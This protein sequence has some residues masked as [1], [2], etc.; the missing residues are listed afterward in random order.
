MFGLQIM[1]YFGS[2]LFLTDLFCSYQTACCCCSL[3]CLRNEM[4][5]VSS[6]AHALPWQRLFPPVSAPF[7]PRIVGFSLVPLARPAPLRSTI[8]CSGAPRP[9]SSSSY[10]RPFT[11][12][13]PGRQ[14][15]SKSI[16]MT[17]SL[18]YCGNRISGRM[19]MWLLSGQS[20]WRGEAEGDLWRHTLG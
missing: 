2:E 16:P 17:S 15:A 8:T 20:S 6:L 5:L 4:C 19:A 9:C 14:N 7:Q 12:A 11:E 18:Q 1:H 10:K 13:T 3:Y